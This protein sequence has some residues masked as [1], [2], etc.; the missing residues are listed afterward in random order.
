MLQR[1]N[2]RQQDKMASSHVLL[3]PQL[4]D[5]QFTVAE[6]ERN[7]EIF[8]F[9]KLESDFSFLYESTQIK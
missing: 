5:I 2:L 9:K 7:L 6:E 8:T 3:C 1:M 4:N